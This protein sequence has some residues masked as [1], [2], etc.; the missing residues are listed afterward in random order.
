MHIK[1]LNL[2]GT[3]IGQMR[4]KSKL[5]MFWIPADERVHVLR[6][7]AIPE[8][9]ALTPPLFFLFNQPH[10]PTRPTPYP[11]WVMACVDFLSLWEVVLHGL[12]LSSC[13]HACP[14]NQ[15][16]NPSWYLY[17]LWF[18][19]YSCSLSSSPF[20][21][22]PAISLFGFF[23]LAPSPLPTRPSPLCLSFP[24]NVFI[25]WSVN[26]FQFILSSHFPTPKTLSS[27]ESVRIP[28]NSDQS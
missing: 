12:P 21:S 19:W 25:L 22:P 8:C 23:Y 18:S 27:S 15:L 3:H 1:H 17:R 5:F 28:L 14:F 26:I 24:D 11:A 9:Y 13:F 10:S 16:G 20:T 7:L 2:P 4:K 6:A